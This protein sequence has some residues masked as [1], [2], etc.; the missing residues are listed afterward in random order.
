MRR[1]LLLLT[2]IIAASPAGARGD[3]I[4]PYGY[5][6]MTCLDPPEAQWGVNLWYPNSQGQVVDQSRT[7]LGP[8]TYDLWVN[9]ATLTPLAPPSLRGVQQGFCIDAFQNIYVNQGYNNFGVYDLSAAFPGQPQITS[10]VEKLWYLYGQS[11]DPNRAA[12]LTLALW[13]VAS[14]TSGTFDVT[15]G[16]FYVTS[17]AAADTTLANQWL[18]E[19]TDDTT[20]KLR[21]A[22]GLYALIEE[23]VQT[24]CLLFSGLET[25]EPGLAVS[26][27]GLAAIGLPAGIVKILRR[28]RR[29]GITIRRLHRLRRK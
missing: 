24:Q 20:N 3:A 16:N 23:G 18:Q 10:D 22:T 2:L 11:S 27:L 19:L 25:P 15:Q 21:K 4:P 29:G 26:L 9:S 8:Y 13:E 28:G 1:S 5:V 7:A 17:V 12:A 6:G 14:E